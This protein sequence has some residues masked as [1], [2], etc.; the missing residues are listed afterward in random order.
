MTFIHSTTGWTQVDL[1]DY[2]KKKNMT[3][4]WISQTINADLFS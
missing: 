1:R 3:N 2:E 4:M